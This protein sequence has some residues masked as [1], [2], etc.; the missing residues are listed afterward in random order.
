MSNNQTSQT[1][2]YILKFDPRI[3]KYTIISV[4][5]TQKYIFNLNVSNNAPVKNPGNKHKYILYDVPKPNFKRD[6]ITDLCKSFE[7]L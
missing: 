3:N 7:Q 6:E 5:K 2:K 1:Q 4:P